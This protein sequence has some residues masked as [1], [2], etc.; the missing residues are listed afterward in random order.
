MKTR[1]ELISA[2]LLTS[3]LSLAEALN[4]HPPLVQPVIAYE[5]KKTDNAIK[6]LLR[7]KKIRDE[8]DIAKRID[9]MSYHFMGKPY[10][11]D[12]LGEGP[13]GKFDQSPRYRIDCF[14]NKAFVS[15]ILALSHAKTLSE[16][17]TNMRQIQYNKGKIDFLHRKHFISI[18]W[19][20]QTML[21]D[22]T[23]N[24]VDT[25]GRFLALDTETWINKD[26][27]FQQIKTL[28]WLKQPEK[29]ED[30]KKQLDTLQTLAKG[31]PPIRNRL[32]Y[33]PLTRLFDKNGRPYNR[34][35]AQIPSGTVLELVSPNDNHNEE[36]HT[37]LTTTSNITHLGLVIRKQGRLYF[38]EASIEEKTIIETPL[39]TFLKNYL[40]HATIKG[41][42]LEQIV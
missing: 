10:L 17:K 8:K 6:K 22:I 3:T 36:H 34:L 19:N 11:S 40:N 7:N 41:I 13:T 25:Q 21:R 4:T 30:A 39:A 35:F 20:K 1:F 28:K 23:R 16:F 32:P 31:Q 38:R 12:A 33:V 37:P 18:D 5:M 15:T 9:Q 14:D 27:W 24:L 26:H 2:L 42:H 29:E